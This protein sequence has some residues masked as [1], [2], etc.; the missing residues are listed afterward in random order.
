[1]EPRETRRTHPAGV[2]GNGILEGQGGA[3]APP[4]LHVGTHVL[5]PGIRI[6]KRKPH[7]TDKAFKHGNADFLLKCA[8][9]YAREK[10]FK[11]EQNRLRNDED[12]LALLKELSKKGNNHIKLLRDDDDGHLYMETH[13]QA[14]EDYTV[15]HIPIGPTYRMRKATGNLVRRFVRAFAD[16]LHIPDMLNIPRFDYENEIF[17]EQVRE[18]ELTYH[19]TKDDQD[20]PE[21]FCTKEWI[22]FH[23]EYQEGGE[24]YERLMEFR[25]IK[26]LTEDEL[27]RFKPANEAERRLAEYLERGFEIIRTGIN[28]DN[29]RETLFMTETEMIQFQDSGIIDW[30]DLMFV[31]YERDDMTDT[32]LENLNCDIQSG[33]VTE[34]IVYGGRLPESGPLNF[35]EEVE[36][37]I[38]YIDKLVDVL[39]DGELSEKKKKTT[40]AA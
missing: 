21:N 2:F 22:D 32:L 14:N 23:R 10:G 24:P 36:D 25:H 11:L 20:K 30:E 40:K 33:A 5:K 31:C 15:Y 19:R 18:Q 13:M 38:K 39:E 6:R 1:M 8:R 16:Q 12:M 4:V 28:L 7:V 34:N 26:P 17:E 35:N 37:A 3:Y 9:N 29:Q 27:R